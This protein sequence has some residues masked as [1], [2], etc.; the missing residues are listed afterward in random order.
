MRVKGLK[1]K[2]RINQQEMKE[3]L[4][5]IKIRDASSGSLGYFPEL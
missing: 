5:R 2:A 1:E 3:M 4:Q